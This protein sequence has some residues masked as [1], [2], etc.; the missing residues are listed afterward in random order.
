[1]WGDNRYG[2]CYV[3]KL[4][5]R[6]RY[7]GIF[8]IHKM[9]VAPSAS[10]RLEMKDF[11]WLPYFLCAATSCGEKFASLPYFL[12]LAYRHV[13]EIL[14]DSGIPSLNYTVKILKK[15]M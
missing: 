11:F 8:K 6:H 12:E 2:I 9:A 3:L 4:W 10:V 5:G 14:P 1:M 15:K 7:G 13:Q